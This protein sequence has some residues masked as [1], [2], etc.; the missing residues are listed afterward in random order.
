MN[1]QMR[2]RTR[3]FRRC[4]RLNRAYRLESCQKGRNTENH[5]VKK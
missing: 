4:V 1:T 5:I 3:L 2:A